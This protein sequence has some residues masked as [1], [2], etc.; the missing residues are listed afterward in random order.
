M[1]VVVTNLIS[2]QQ[3]VSTEVNLLIRNSVEI[4]NKDYTNIDNM[5]QSGNKFSR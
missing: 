5:R 1:N 4:D 2:L 3:T